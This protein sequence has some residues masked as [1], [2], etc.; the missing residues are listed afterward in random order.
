MAA[1]REVA[2]A[3]AANGYAPVPVLA[4]TKRPALDAWQHY[5]YHDGDDERYADCSCGG[6]SGIMLPIAIDVRNA[7]LAAACERIFVEAFGPTIRRIGAPP[8]SA[9][10]YRTATPFRKLSSVHVRLPG[11][12]PDAKP[13]AVEILAQGQQIVLYGTH[14]DGHEYTWNGVGDPLEHP[15]ASLPAVT[16]AELLQV[17]LRINALLLER[18]EPVGR[19][20]RDAGNHASS[21]EQIARRSE[22]HTSELQS[23]LNL[24]C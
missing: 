5:A 2:A 24:V 8:K 20:A 13:H 18:G 10:I 12:A 21:D 7:A 3:L 15:L 6:L 1:F 14:P 17:L 19:L 16:E 23:P 9:L 4:R 11:D 22:E